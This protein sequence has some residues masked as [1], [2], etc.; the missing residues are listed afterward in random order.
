MEYNIL[1][2]SLYIR[3]LCIAVVAELH[4]D[5]GEHHEQLR[6]ITVFVVG[7]QEP[8]DAGTCRRGLSRRD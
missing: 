8:G 7:L 1:L 4:L 6:A 5:G 2:M 3:D